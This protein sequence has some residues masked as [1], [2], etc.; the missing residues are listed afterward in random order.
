[1]VHFDR[2]DFSGEARGSEGNNHARLQDTGLDTA[3]GTV[4]IPPIL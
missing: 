4:P 3:T 2:L 1:V